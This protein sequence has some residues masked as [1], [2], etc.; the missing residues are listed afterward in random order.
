MTEYRNK[1]KN[2]SYTE[3]QIIAG[4]TKALREG[5]TTQQCLCL[6]WES[7]GLAESIRER[8]V[9]EAFKIA[10]NPQDTGWQQI[11]A[12]AAPTPAAPPAAP[13]TAPVAS[14]RDLS[15]IHI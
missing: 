2:K 15:L 1:Q 7:Y 8:L 13:Q 12:Q 4:L 14:I 10:Q 11:A 3:A 5:K 9:A 6:L